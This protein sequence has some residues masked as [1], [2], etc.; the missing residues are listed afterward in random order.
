MKHNLNL[1]V[2]RKVYNEK[3]SIWI[4]KNGASRIVDATLRQL[5]KK[6]IVK[7]RVLKSA[8]KRED[9]RNIAAR[10]AQETVSTVNDVRGHT[11]V[12]YKPRKRK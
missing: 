10:I 3:P 11:F 4:G 8:L 12:L 2:K 1:R 5:D 6:E 9:I 7:V